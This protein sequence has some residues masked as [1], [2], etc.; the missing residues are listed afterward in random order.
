MI[1]HVNKQPTETQDYVT[2]QNWLILYKEKLIKIY[3]LI[4]YG[5]LI[6]SLTF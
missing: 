2:L 5:A 4:S 6:Y 1:C 3:L